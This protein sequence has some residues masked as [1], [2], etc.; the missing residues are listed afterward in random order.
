M[1]NFE[2]NSSFFF[3]SGNNGYINQNPGGVGWRSLW[4]PLRIR[5]SFRSST[6]AY[7]SHNTECLPNNPPNRRVLDEH[8]YDLYAVCNHHGT[9]L[10]G[11]HY[12]GKIRVK[13]GF[14]YEN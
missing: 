10:V 6:N 4:S 3:T 13:N 9:G 1:P 2:L 5:S 12:T 14:K 11:G 8:V 7:N